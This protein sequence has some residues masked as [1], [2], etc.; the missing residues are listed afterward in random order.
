VPTFA[1]AD[2]AVQIA[3]GAFGRPAWSPDGSQIAFT[4]GRLNVYV[5][6]STGGCN[7]GITNDLAE[8]SSPAWSP[9]GSMIAFESDRGGSDNIWVIPVPTTAVQSDSSSGV[10]EKYKE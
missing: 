7:T 2:N 10:K 6:P 9:D 5:V 4:L 1:A 8:D 3:A